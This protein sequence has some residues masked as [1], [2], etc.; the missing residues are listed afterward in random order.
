[1]PGLVGGDLGQGGADGRIGGAR[2]LLGGEDGGDGLA[3][4]PFAHGADGERGQAR[5]H[6]DPVADRE[7]PR[8]HRLAG[9]GSGEREAELGVADLVEGGPVRAREQIGGRA[10]REEREGE[11]RERGHRR[12]LQERVR[13]PG[14]GERGA[15]DGVETVHRGIARARRA[16]APRGC[17][18][19]DRSRA[20]RMIVDQVGAAAADAPLVVDH[21]A[22]LAGHSSVPASTTALASMVGPPLSVPASVQ[23][24]LSRT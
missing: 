5:A 15:L 17:P 7:P 13:G 18:P 6:V 3:H 4:A 10:G 12:V 9:V 22:A 24:F 20:R 21:V 11:A 14:R 16:R 23:P 2:V 8:R 19:E 1:M